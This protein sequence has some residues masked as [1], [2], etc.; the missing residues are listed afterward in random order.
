MQRRWCGR[1]C[2]WR[3]TATAPCSPPHSWP[4][5]ISCPTLRPSNASV[6]CFAGWMRAAIN[7][8][9][10]SS[11]AWLQVSCKSEGQLHDQGAS[12]ARCI[13]ARLA[14]QLCTVQDGKHLRILTDILENKK[15]P[16][17][18]K[19]AVCTILR[20]GAQAEAVSM[21]TLTQVRTSVNSHHLDSHHSVHCSQNVAAAHQKLPVLMRHTDSEAWTSDGGT[22][23]T[24]IAR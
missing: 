2:A 15:S 18:L 10:L 6:R 1:C 3:A 4:W 16:L 7:L 24:F 8:C 20:A 12:S 11:L 5:A 19:E 14:H 22:E 23:I 13:Q 9:E 17:S 21:S